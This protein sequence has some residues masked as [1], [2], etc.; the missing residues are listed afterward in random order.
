MCAIATLSSNYTRK[1]V[2]PASKQRASA[3]FKNRIN[4]HGSKT[5]LY[6]AG[7]VGKVEGKG[8]R[9]GGGERCGVMGRGGR[10]KEVRKEGDGER[11]G[12]G[13][14]G[15][16]RGMEWGGEREGTNVLLVGDNGDVRC[17]VS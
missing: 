8:E 6:T 11:R 5:S 10:W 2:K 15:R 13:K 1:E 9:E 3:K 16:W 4:L 14:E 7:L 17:M 12:R